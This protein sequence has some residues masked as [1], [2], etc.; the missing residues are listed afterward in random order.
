MFTLIHIWEQFSRANPRSSSFLDSWRKPENPE[1]KSWLNTQISKE[2]LKQTLPTAPPFV[3]STHHIPCIF[4]YIVNEDK[5][6]L[7]LILENLEEL[8]FGFGPCCYRYMA[9]YSKIKGPPVHSF[10]HQSGELMAIG[11]CN[12][13]SITAGNQSIQLRLTH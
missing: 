3:P 13:F 8:T 4:P 9:S 10:P 12:Q 7:D 2:F 1:E 11:G 6:P 5:D